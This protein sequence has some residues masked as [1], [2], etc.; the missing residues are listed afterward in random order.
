M[1]Y[2]AA[3][4]DT[5][6]DFYVVVLN[7][8]P[9]N[10]TMGILV[11]TDYH[12]RRV[13]PQHKDIIMVCCEQNFF[14]CQIEFRFSSTMTDKTHMISQCFKISL[15]SSRRH[16]IGSL[17]LGSNNLAEPAVILRRMIEFIL[18]RLQLSVHSQKFP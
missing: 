2:G 15:I 13:L 11:A 4:A 6:D 18:G 17:P 1:V 5:A 12:G 14:Q 3:T 16:P 10:F 9:V 8:F 7:I